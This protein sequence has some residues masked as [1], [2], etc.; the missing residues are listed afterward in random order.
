MAPPEHSGFSH[1]GSVLSRAPTFSSRRTHVDHEPELTSTNITTTS[2]N[3]AASHDS[4]KYQLCLKSRLFC[5]IMGFNVFHRKCSPKILHTS[6]C[7]KWE[8][9]LFSMKKLLNM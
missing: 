9:W 3:D 8:I 1:V 7:P 6:V 2:D 4:E 5:F